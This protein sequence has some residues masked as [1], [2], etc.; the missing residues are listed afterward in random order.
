MFFFRFRITFANRLQRLSF[1]YIHMIFLLFLA[2]EKT[3]KFLGMVTNNNPGLVV[4]A[5]LSAVCSRY[6]AHRYL[7]GMSA[8]VVFRILWNLPES[9]SDFILCLGRPV[10]V[11]LKTS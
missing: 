4:D 11:N 3:K 7:V 8:Q 1:E 2:I 10:P 5:Y 6:P 9:I